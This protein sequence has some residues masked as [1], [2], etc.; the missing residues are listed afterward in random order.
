MKKKTIWSY[1]KRIIIAVICVTILS[2]VGIYVFDKYD[3]T[4]SDFDNMYS[5]EYWDKLEGFK[6]YE[7]L[8][9]DEDKYNIL[10]S[11]Y[12]SPYDEDDNVFDKINKSR[13][14][15]E[16]DLVVKPIN[17]NLVSLKNQLANLK[18]LNESSKETW[19]LKI[20]S[21]STFVT[22]KTIYEVL[23]DTYT[24]TE[25]EFY[26]LIDNYENIDLYNSLSANGYSD[27]FKKVIEAV[28]SS[29]DSAEL[30]AKSQNEDNYS[31]TF[32]QWVMDV[33]GFNK[34][35]TPEKFSAYDYARLHGYTGSVDQW[36]DLLTKYG[37]V[38]L[39]LS[40]Q[41]YKNP[42]N[43]I[44][45]DYDLY[46][47][48]YNDQ[49]KQD[50]EDN[51][52]V[53]SA[54]DEAKEANP[55]EVA[56]LEKEIDQL[57]I[58]IDE[59]NLV[60]AKLPKWTDYFARYQKIFSNANYEFWFSY[61]L[62]T[63][64]IVDLN[65]GYEW[66]SNPETVVPTLASDQKTVISVLYGTS[67]GAEIP[68]SN[69]DYSVSTLNKQNRE[70][71]PN[72]AVK[73][74][75]EKNLVQ[76]WYRL[77]KRGLDYT[78]FPQ[79][80]SETR[81]KQLIQQNKERAAAGM[82]DSSG[83]KIPDIEEMNKIYE[84][85]EKE[86]EQLKKTYNG[87]ETDP[88]FIE[89]S[90]RLEAIKKE[91]EPGRE[92]YSK[93]LQ[94]YYNILD[95]DSP[96]NLVKYNYYEWKG[97]TKFEFMSQI[98][99]KNLYKW[100]YEWCG[101]NR[102][103]LAADNREFNIE[104][105]LSSQAFEVAMEYKLTDKGLT[106]NIPGNSLREYGDY[107][108]SKLDILPYFTSTPEGVG[109]YTLIPDGSGAIMEHDNNKSNLYDPYIKRIYTTDLSETS[110]TKKATSYDIM[111]PMYAVV[112]N[113][114][115]GSAAVIVDAENMASQLELRATT[116]GFGTLGE[117]H[118]RN[119]FK[120]YVRESQSVF[121]GTY[122]KEEVKKFTNQLLTED[123]V[124]N[125]NFLSDNHNK[126]DY[127]TIAKLYRD[128][129]IDR[130]SFVTEDGVSYS[131]TEKDT[132]TSPVLDIDVIGAY[133][134]RD[135]FLGISYTAKDTMTTYEQLGKMIDDFKS[136]DVTDSENNVIKED[137]IKYINVFY[138]GWR[139]EALVNVTFKSLK[140]N[141]L[142]G[143]KEQLK[144]LSEK[145]NV[146]IYPYLSFGEVNSYQESFGS[147]HY[148][149]RDV[150]GEIIVKQQYAL[151]TN[152]YDPKARTISI[153]SPHYYFVF[154][155]SLVDSYVK[156]FG[157]KAAQDNKVGIN[158]IS[159]DKFGS[160]L[161]GDYKKNNEMFK[162]GAMREQI[163]SLQL[164]YE[165]VENINLYKPY[166]YAFN[167]IN[168]AKDIPYQATQKEI[169][170]YSIPFYQLVVNGL[171]DYSGESINVNIEDGIQ[172]HIMK[173]IE[174]GSNP[175]F[176]FTF[177]SSSELVRTEYNYYYNTEYINWLSEVTKVF[178]ELDSLGIYQG[179]LVKHERLAPNI[180]LVTYLVNGSEIEIVLNYSF[181]SYIYNTNVI[182]P[183]KSYK[184]L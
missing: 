6:K 147:N 130:Y 75:M 59:A 44:D 3:S 113:N 61:G 174:T 62:T 129:L 7:E 26:D 57:S 160:A 71:T 88:V 89:E 58:I 159:I 25:N 95:A 106:L 56:L 80:M 23:S 72:Y 146:T 76:V 69:Y 49:G 85:A 81:V 166:D 157:S 40:L 104:I 35:V 19:M 158:S 32:E 163:R 5:S 36:K 132:T 123:I 124:I 29:K 24:G 93:W 84:A 168:H 41:G 179:R 51:W 66:Y 140:L 167:Y 4:N 91:A 53:K 64:K 184:K 110:S 153:V 60:S 135:N 142:L 79:Y 94:S 46:M 16:L 10:S 173:M 149:T 156:L 30:Y 183:A 116:S 176:T 169:F 164:I 180:Y 65:S 120:A 27:T 155:Q 105:D 118:N 78:Y 102:G 133:T 50:V 170:D 8:K 21:I 2:F 112:N 117:T 136:L 101:Y 38:F 77:E 54:Y 144:A 63:F 98:V 103:E 22:D 11:K 109:G 152:T 148:T 67:A 55:E 137:I 141:G 34:Y 161:A 90:A 20:L 128:I 83:A 181:A 162:S 14:V 125:Y 178:N 82:V 70:V 68:Y 87:N 121:I 171:F 92:A 100:L 107:K 111:L 1:L 28:A 9:A 31:G 33:C 131:L 42:I 182:V 138:H 73:V 97:A 154:A 39:E 165:T 115:N 139:K 37:E 114:G 48:I 108:I 15:E 126:I 96:S 17:N 119:N 151:N 45:S 12:E 143:S 175:Q 177:D 127:S 47:A 134:Y 122:A 18:K 43:G 150:V 145:N 99:I 172:Q 52:I 74:D 86:L 13:Y